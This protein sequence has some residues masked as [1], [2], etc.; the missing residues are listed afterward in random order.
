M[1]PANFPER[2]RQR[3]I[4]ALSRMKTQTAGKPEKGIPPSS[5]HSAIAALR[6]ATL[7][8]RR[9]VRTKKDRS[10]DARFFRA[11]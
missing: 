9:D 10:K 11:D 6:S 1:K 8:S 3:Q 5:N 4:G 7:N 2:K